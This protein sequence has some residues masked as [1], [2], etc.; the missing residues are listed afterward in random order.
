MA[1]ELTPLNP[2]IGSE[3]TGVDLATAGDNQLEEVKAALLEQK[4]L[5][6]RDQKLT[7]E[8][9][10]AIGR[11]FGTGKLH[12]HALNDSGDP[13]YLPVITDENSKYTPGDGWHTDVSCDPNPIAVSM[14][15]ITQIPASGGGDTLFTNMNASYELLSEPVK[16][17]CHKLTAIHDGAFPY[18]DVYGVEPEGAYNK[19]E[20]PVVIQ[21]PETGEPILWVNR[22]FTTKLKGCG[23]DESK[24]LLDMLYAHIA[25]TPKAQCRVRWENNTLVMWDNVATQHH[26]TWDYFPEKRV[27]ARVSVVG[28]EIRAA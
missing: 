24:Y 19:T 25:Q 3:V 26:A 14:L 4:V 23:F 17:L 20:H 18:R 8:Q 9:H 7:P 12:Q 11:V 21:H 5:V 28:R 6:F 27:G 10:K 16:E 13:Y 2:V 15:Y 22:G 1:M